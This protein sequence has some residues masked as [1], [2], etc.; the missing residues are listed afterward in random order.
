MIAGKTDPMIDMAEVISD[1]F[2]YIGFAFV[3]D[4]HVE[5]LADT[6]R[7]FLTAEKIAIDEQSAIAYFSN[8]EDH[9]KPSRR[10][11]AK[12]RLFPAG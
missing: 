9:K 4:R 11:R 5:A 1:L 10:S 12:R 7:D 8:L 2:S 6:L 3:E